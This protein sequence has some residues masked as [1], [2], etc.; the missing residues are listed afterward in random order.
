MWFYFEN[1]TFVLRLEVSMDHNIHLSLRDL[2]LEAVTNFWSSL[3]LPPKRNWQPMID[4]SCKRLR[5]F[6]VFHFLL[7]FRIDDV[8]LNISEYF[9]CGIFWLPSKWMDAVLWKCIDIFLKVAVANLSSCERCFKY[10]TDAYAILLLS[11]NYSLINFQSLFSSVFNLKYI[12]NCIIINI[13][14]MSHR[15]FQRLIIIATSK[16]FEGRIQKIYHVRLL[17]ISN[18]KLNFWFIK[19][20]V[21][22][23]WLKLV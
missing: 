2:S 12:Q 18:K 6:K 20:N 13:E 7:W 23:H 14:W 11:M 8:D 19:L 5:G 15:T 21:L 4:R 17:G 16:I 1:P 9:S 22:R 3:L 10:L